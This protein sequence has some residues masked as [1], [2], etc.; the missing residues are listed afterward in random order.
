MHR[1]KFM[2]AYERDCTVKLVY[3]VCMCLTLLSNVLMQVNRGSIVYSAIT[4]DAQPAVVLL[5]RAALRLLITTAA[6]TAGCMSLLE[7]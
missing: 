6:T 7:Y 4:I 1:D 5:T 2:I 3:C